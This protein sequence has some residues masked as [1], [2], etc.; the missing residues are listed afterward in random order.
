MGGPGPASTTGGQANMMD[1]SCSRLKL[2]CCSF[3]L[4][5]DSTTWSFIYMGA[6]MVVMDG[7]MEEV[8][9]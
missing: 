2:R 1:Y 8:M 4:F 9:K 3:S 5:N 7:E 6:R